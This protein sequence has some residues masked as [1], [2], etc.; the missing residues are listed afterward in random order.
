MRRFKDGDTIT[1]E[2]WRA[3]AFPIIKDLVTDR[4]A[5]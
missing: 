4:R 3:K 5:F 1:V 2:P